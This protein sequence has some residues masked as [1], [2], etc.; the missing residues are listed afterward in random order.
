[1]V[2]FELMPL[3]FCPQLSSLRRSPRL[4]LAVVVVPQSMKNC[5]SDFKV[6]VCIQGRQRLALRDWVIAVRQTRHPRRTNHGR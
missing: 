5:Q 6:V 4:R 3:N 2:H 1:M